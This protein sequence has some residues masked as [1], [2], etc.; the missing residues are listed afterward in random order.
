MRPSWRCSV[1]FSIFGR[2]YTAEMPTSADSKTKCVANG[3]PVT[4]QTI[5]Q[6]RGT[7]EDSDINLADWTLSVAAI[8]KKKNILTIK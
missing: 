2:T 8:G 3:S 1:T 6:Q 5:R 7:G 4:H